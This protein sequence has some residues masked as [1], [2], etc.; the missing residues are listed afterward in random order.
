MAEQLQGWHP[1]PYGRHKERYFSRGS[2]TE[3]AR[4]GLDEFEDPVPD[5]AI[6]DPLPGAVVQSPLDDNGTSTSPPSSPQPSHAESTPPQ[7]TDY[8]TQFP[9]PGPVPEA[10]AIGNPIERLVG[11]G[12]I[13]GRPLAEIVEILGRPT[14]TDVVP[15]DRIL[16]QWMHNPGDGGPY[17]HYA[18]RFDV[19]L[20]CGGI[21]QEFYK[22]GHNLQIGQPV[23]MSRGQERDQRV[24]PRCGRA[25]FKKARGV[26]GMAVAGVLAPK[27]HAK[28]RS[29]GFRMTS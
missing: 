6:A 28:C 17:W 13:A 29:C 5:P 24:C 3:L 20:I 23:K 15:P 12:T 22:P 1:D 16:V 26:G 9:Y 4:D 8:S 14:S 10:A 27:T 2:P 18:M 25:G 11:M 7:T 21:T 19:N